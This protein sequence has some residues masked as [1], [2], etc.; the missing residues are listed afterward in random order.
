M[1]Y[2]IRT[3]QKS[4]LADTAT[5]V[6]LYLKFRDLFPG[7]ILLESSDYHGGQDNFSFI[8]L[9]P[10]TGIQIDMGL[11]TTTFPDQEPSSYP[12]ENI[13]SVL[14][15]FFNSFTPI[16]HELDHLNGFFGYMS[17]DAAP[18]FEK[19]PKQDNNSEYRLHCFFLPR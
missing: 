5:P 18:Y 8:C 2:Q 19:V 7:S 4:I 11:V 17:Y 15:D 12:S 16:N 9:S 1:K 13:P 10:L 14:E 6:S 3:Y